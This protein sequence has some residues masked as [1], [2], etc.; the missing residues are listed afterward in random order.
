MPTALFVLVF[1]SVIPYALVGLGGYAKIQHS[2]ILIIIIHAC[3]RGN[4]VVEP[5]EPLRRSRMLGKRWHFIAQPFLPW[6]WVVFHGLISPCLRLCLLLLEWHIPSCTLRILPSAGLWSLS[7]ASLAVFICFLS[8]FKF[9]AT[10]CT[11]LSCVS[12][13]Q[14][15]SCYSFA[16]FKSPFTLWRTE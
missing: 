15:N 2:V 14:W 6:V 16:N 7:L 10:F 1:V 4:L 5:Q 3:R 11:K 8:R 12:D 13:Q 9:C